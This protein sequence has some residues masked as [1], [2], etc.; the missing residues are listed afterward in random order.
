MTERAVDTAARAADRKQPRS[1]YADLARSLGRVV[2][3]SRRPVVC[4]QGLGFVGAAMAAAVAHSRDGEGRAQFDV[5]GV[6][7]PTPEGQAKVDALNNVRFPMPT[8]D[9]RLVAEIETAA[10]RGNLLATTDVRAF[11]LA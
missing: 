4:I 2:P 6:D 10:R 11:A 8:N 7:L 3:A 9:A 5:V 1:G